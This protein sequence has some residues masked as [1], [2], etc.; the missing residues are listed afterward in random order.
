[1]GE[2]GLYALYREKHTLADALTL[3]TTHSLTKKFLGRLV[4]MQFYP[5]PVISDLQPPRG[6]IICLPRRNINNPNSSMQ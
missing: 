5:R 4:F 3:A 2:R 6:R 1:M